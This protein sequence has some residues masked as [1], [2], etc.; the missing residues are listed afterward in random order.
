MQAGSNCKRPLIL[1]GNLYRESYCMRNLCRCTAGKHCCGRQPCCACWP[2]WSRPSCR[3]SPRWSPPTAPLKS[4][5]WFRMAWRFCCPWQVRTLPTSQPGLSSC[6]KQ[7]NMDVE[8]GQLG[9]H[10]FGVRCQ[11]RSSKLLILQ[12]VE[13]LQASQVAVQPC[14]GTAV[15]LLPEIRT[16]L[17]SQ[18]DSGVQGCSIR[19]RRRHAC[20]S[21]RPRYAH[22]SVLTCI[23]PALDPNCGTYCSNVGRLQSYCS[24]PPTR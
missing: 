20:V 19:R 7:L 23:S 1:H 10:M 17:L 5:W 11:Q 12:I 24:N 14:F 15:N 21:K 6:K 2:S 9:I 16:F 4:S 18:L 8:H 22:G 13:L 3:S